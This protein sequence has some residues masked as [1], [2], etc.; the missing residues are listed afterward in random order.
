MAPCVTAAGEAADGVSTIVFTAAI[1]CVAFIVG[2][3]EQQSIDL[4]S[5]RQFVECNY[6]GI[7]TST[8]SQPVAVTQGTMKTD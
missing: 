3:K 6:I 7:R 1:C 5:Q 2:I 8:N 4:V